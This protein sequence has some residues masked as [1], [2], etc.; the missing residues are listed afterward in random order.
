MTTVL[1]YLLSTP[2]NIVFF[3]KEDNTGDISQRML[4]L[5]VRRDIKNNTI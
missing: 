1:F 5:V 2:G 4:T 3:L